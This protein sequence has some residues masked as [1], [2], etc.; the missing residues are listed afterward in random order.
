MTRKHKELEAR[1]VG[2]IEGFHR[3]LDTVKR[4]TRIYDEYLHRVK[5]LIDEKPKDVIDLAQRGENSELDVV[6]LREQVQKLESELEQ[7]KSK[8]FRPALRPE[9]DREPDPD[10][11]PHAEHDNTQDQDQEQESQHAAEL[12]HEPEHA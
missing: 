11:V 12:E 5:H 1:R 6:P 8:H 3:D 9:H 2:E 4:K 10:A 7:I